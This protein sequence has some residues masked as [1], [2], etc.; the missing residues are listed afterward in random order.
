MVYTTCTT[1]TS[2]FFYIGTSILFFACGFLAREMLQ[3]LIEIMA[4]CIR[5]KRLEKWIKEQKRERGK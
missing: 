1:V 5:S 2:P 3:G 4:E